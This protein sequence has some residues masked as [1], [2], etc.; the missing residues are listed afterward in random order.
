MQW[1]IVLVPSTGFSY[2]NLIETAKDTGLMLFS[3][4]PRGS[5]ISIAK[6]EAMKEVM[7]NVLVPSTGF[8]YLNTRKSDSG[9][10]RIKFS[11]PP[12]GS[13]IS[14][15]TNIV[16]MANTMD[17]LVPSTGF[18]Y[19]NLRSCS[20]SASTNLFSSP[21]RGSLIS[22]VIC[23]IGNTCTTGS[24]PLHGVLLSQLYNTTCMAIVA[25]VLVPSTGF[26]YLNFNTSHKF[27]E[28]IMFSSPPRGSLISI[29]AKTIWSLFLIPSSRPLH[30]VLLSQ[31]ALLYSDDSLFICSRPLHG[32]LIFQSC[33]LHLSK[34]KA[35][36]PHLRGKPA[37]ERNLN[38]KLDHTDHKA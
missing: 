8:S 38:I 27:R 3:S 1:K 17:V 12:R 24:R 30:G 20:G 9:T 18:S 5:L 7:N 31:F 14:I 10:A 35:F 36:I 28:I 6:K 25:T 37:N 16:Y 11:S 32:V 4:S 19:L 13:L 15:Q 26:S 34:H 23:V 22:M 29:I 21:P 2:L 33:P